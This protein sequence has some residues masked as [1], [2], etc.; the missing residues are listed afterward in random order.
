[1]TDGFFCL[2]DDP[3]ICEEAYEFLFSLCD[4]VRYLGPEW[5]EVL[6][7]EILSAVRG[8]ERGN[9]WNMEGNY[10]S[11]SLTEP[12]K[13]MVREHSL[14]GIVPLDDGSCLENLSLFLGE[15]RLY[16][17]CSH[18]GYTDADETFLTRVSDFCL[19][20]IGSAKRYLAMKERYGVL[21]RSSLATLRREFRI[22]GDLSN[23]VS[24]AIGDWFYFAPRVPCSFEKFCAVAK[25]F[26]TPDLAEEIERA[27]SF[28]NL[29]PPGAPDMAAMTRDIEAHGTLLTQEERDAILNH[30]KFSDGELARRVRDEL[31]MLEVVFA[32]EEGVSLRGKD[33]APTIVMRR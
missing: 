28:S 24:E 17:V 22:L 2:I 20:K 11:F 8:V 26:L 23:Y 19:E 7:A 12:V 32:R 1:M 15:E 25:K 14:G 9:D 3:E 5:V 6:D 16:A 18:E 13:R 31:N 33:G 27:G 21:K 4:R 30:P 29:H 10:I